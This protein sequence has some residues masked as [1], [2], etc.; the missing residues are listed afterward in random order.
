MLTQYQEPAT[1]QP[2]DAERL[3]VPAPAA[4]IVRRGLGAPH[5]SDYLDPVLLFN[6]LA[7]GLHWS[8]RF[9]LV[10]QAFGNPSHLS[11]QARRMRPWLLG[12]GVPVV[13]GLLVSAFFVVNSNVILAAG[14]AA[15]AMGGVAHLLFLDPAV[16][17]AAFP[18][19]IEG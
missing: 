4:P 2:D 6:A 1:Q 8:A 14:L 19:S 11:A 15:L 7:L 10:S 5:L 12:T 16:Q 17:R 9:V 13:A 18:G 3:E